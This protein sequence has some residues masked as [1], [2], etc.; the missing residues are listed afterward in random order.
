MQAEQLQDEEGTG[1]GREL[2]EAGIHVPVIGSYSPCSHLKKNVH[3]LGGIITL[4]NY[5]RVNRSVSHKKVDRIRHSWLSTQQPLI[6]I[7]WL[8]ES[9]F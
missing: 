4:C 9:L 3:Q 2:N 7:F 1:G 5:I 8:T 6:L